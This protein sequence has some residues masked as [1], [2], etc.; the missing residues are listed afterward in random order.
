MSSTNPSQ[1]RSGELLAAPPPCPQRPTGAAA[2]PAI[3]PD[4]A[5]PLAERLPLP[6]D[7]ITEAFDPDPRLLDPNQRALL[8]ALARCGQVTTA[9]QIVGVRTSSHYAW[10]KQQPLYAEEAQRAR[11]LYLES[12]EREADRRAVQGTLEPVFYQGQVVG[13]KSVYSDTLLMF[14]LKALAPERYRERSEQTISGTLSG[15]LDV[16]QLTDEQLARIAAGADG[17]DPTPGATYDDQHRDQPSTTS[18]DAAPSG[19]G[20]HPPAGGG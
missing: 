5:G 11:Q 4:S 12:M 13:Y 3:V 17:Q 7:E 19:R 8:V 2:R 18:P 6:E 9:C 15:T 1:P 14:R 20:D 10:L 16:S